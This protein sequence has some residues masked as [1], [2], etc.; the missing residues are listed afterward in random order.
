MTQNLFLG[1]IFNKEFN[2]EHGKDKK[3]NIDLLF[4]KLAYELNSASVSLS[5]ATEAIGRSSNYYSNLSKQLDAVFGTDDIKHTPEVAQSVRLSPGDNRNAARPLADRE[6]QS[7][8]GY[9]SLKEFV[10][11]VLAK[12]R[13]AVP[14]D[15]L[16]F[17][18]VDDDNG[19]K[20]IQF[21]LDQNS[22]RT[23]CTFRYIEEFTVYAHRDINNT[24]EEFDNAISN[25][26][27]VHIPLK[28]DGHDDWDSIN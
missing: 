7:G 28:S 6:K 18:T 13:Y 11:A 9:M 26:H 4:N 2:M 3:R 22:G 1:I 24:V 23:W 17:R 14:A 19:V 16:R 5:Q 27:M 10:K 12:S 20:V 21:R 15:I 25:L 8:K